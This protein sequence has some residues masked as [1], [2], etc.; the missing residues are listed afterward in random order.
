MAQPSTKIFAEIIPDTKRYEQSVAEATARGVQKGTQRTFDSRGVN[1]LDKGFRGATDSIKGFDRELD[2]ANRRV[3]SFGAAATV[4]YGT[5]RAF[6]E[7]VVAGVAVEKSLAA[8]NSIIK[9]SQR[10]LDTFG[11]SLF[12]VARETG[13]SFRDTAAAALEFSRQ[14]AGAAETAKRTRD[15][16]LLV[17]LT[18]IETTKAVEGLT[19]MMNTFNKTGIDTTQILNKLVAADDA[20]AV[21]AGGLVEAFT[22]VGSVVTDAGASLDQFIGLVTAARQITGRSEAVIG[23]SLKTIFTRIE[24]SDTLDQLEELGIRVRDASGAARNAYSIFTELGTSY[25]SLTREQQKYVAELSAGVFQINQ[26]K[27]LATDLGKANGIAA[28]ATNTA[29]NS[30]NNALIRNAAL[31]KTLATSIQNLKTSATEAA[32]LI[33]SLTLKPTIDFAVGQGN[34]V[35][36]LFA[37]AKASGD[38]KAG[39]DFGAYMG[40]SILKGLGNVLA[41]PGLILAVKAIMGTAIQVGKNAI[42]DV[43]EAGHFLNNSVASGVKR[44]GIGGREAETASLSTVNGLLNQATTAEMK[45]WKAAE[46][47]AQQEAVILSIIER[48]VMALSAVGRASAAPVGLRGGV[49]STPRSAEG[50]IPMAEESA[51]IRAGVGGAPRSARPVYLPGFRR[52]DGMGIV[53]NTS[54]W[55]AP[56]AAGGY[57]AILNREMIG[58]MGLPPGSKPVAAGGYVPNAAKGG[59]PSEWSSA[60]YYKWKPAVPKMPPFGVPPGTPYTQGGGGFGGG[61]SGQGF[62]QYLKPIPSAS[63]PPFGIPPGTPYTQGHGGFGGGASGQGFGQYLDPVANAAAE[64]DATLRRL[65][66]GMAS[67]LLKSASTI[68][69]NAVLAGFGPILQNGPTMPSTLLANQA[70]AGMGGVLPYGPPAPTSRQFDIKHHLFQGGINAYGRK[71][72]FEREIEMLP[73]QPSSSRGGVDENYVMKKRKEQLDRQTKVQAER[74]SFF[75]RSDERQK[76]IAFGRITDRFSRGIGVSPAQQKFFESQLAIEGKQAAARVL[77]PGASEKAIKGFVNDY[78]QT[79]VQHYDRIFNAAIEAK[80]KAPIA[81]RELASA[82][83]AQDRALRLDRTATRVQMGTIGASFGAAF[84]PEGRGGTG[85]GMGYGALSTGLQGSAVGAGLGSL[86]GP[87]GT[88]AG[89]LVGALGGAI[90]GFINKTQKSFEEL[91]GD[92]EESNRRAATQV[93]NASKVFQLDDEEAELRATGGSPRDLAR[94]RRQRTAAIAALTDRETRNLVLNR[95]SNPKAREEALRA[96]GGIASDTMAGGSLFASLATLRGGTMGGALGKQE[97]EI[98]STGL[99]STVAGLSDSQAKALRSLAASNPDLAVATLA[100]MG[101]LSP[102][103]KEDLAPSITSQIATSPMTLTSGLGGLLG[104]GASWLD[105]R[106]KGSVTEV[107]QKTVDDVDLS[108]ARKDQNRTIPSQVTPRYLLKL[109][110]IL[111]RQAAVG[112]ITPEANLRIDEIGQRALLDRPDL[113]GTARIAREGGFAERNIGARA[114]IQR[115]N[116]LLEGRRSLLGVIGDKQN[117]IRDAGITNAV[118][119]AKTLADLKVVGMDKNATPALRQAIEELSIQME[120]LDRTTAEEINITRAQVDIS[121]KAYQDNLTRTGADRDDTAAIGKAMEAFKAAQDRNEDP[122]IIEAA[123]NALSEAVRQQ[124]V[125]ADPSKRPASDIETLRASI[126]TDMAAKR[127]QHAALMG[128]DRKLLLDQSMEAED[129]DLEERILRAQIALKTAARRGDEEGS[130]SQRRI[131]L[132]DLNMETAF[133]DGVMSEEDLRL[134]RLRNRRSEVGSQRFATGQD[135]ESA[136]MAVA[137]E[138]GLQGD[139]M[140]SF[141]GAFGARFEGLKKD[142]KDLSVVGAQVASSLEQNLGNAFGD[143]ITGVQRGKEAFRAFVLGVLGDSARAFASKAVQSLLGLIFSSFTGLS[144]SA[145]AAAIAGGGS[146]LSAAPASFAGKAAGGSIPAMVM[147]G[148]WI[149]GPAEA[150]RIGPA[151]LSALNSGTYQRRAGGGALVTGGSG[152]GDDVKLGLAQGSYVIR[153][154]MVDRYGPATLAGMAAGGMAV[155]V[156]GALAPMDSFAAGGGMGVSIN[157]AISDMATPVPSLLRGYNSGG[158]TASM[159]ATPTSSGGGSGGALSISTSVTINDQRTSSSTSTEGN[160]GM[161]DKRFGVEM[162]RAIDQAVMRKIEEQTRV[163]GMLRIQSLRGNT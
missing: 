29:A 136:S 45:R 117:P 32:G 5:V 151:K 138:R 38:T 157:S 162:A 108:G 154:A 78:V 53:A 18:G 15:A 49:R 6:K 100:K 125:R 95:A 61:A 98:A 141:T 68:N 13:Q 130:I 58:R 72:S 46:G 3:L 99:Q 103:Q 12:N 127:R 67:T 104:L 131:E 113:F 143:F 102:Q 51:A 11:K 21:S 119:E 158:A 81:A 124:L 56:G 129:Q 19:S 155:S 139:A 54:E 24:R 110:N 34:F 33:G 93:E 28:Q 76:G 17:R 148:E 135:I 128:M 132:R 74:A 30:A 79:R 57:P 105:N 36:E 37:N 63:M 159:T 83:A 126:G 43:R 160:A 86:F 20:F 16:M 75:M 122:V 137:Q 60:D 31:N 9:L 27:A 92:I 112:N 109:G 156:N 116:L 90:T 55:I 41:G 80:G 123:A 66:K 14:G 96:A 145:S 70:I 89:T 77:A 25:S 134:S 64:W 152:Y 118:R 39:E 69:A 144:S 111:A 10:D 4:V 35:A 59:L 82:K 121:T 23:N 150:K 163:G 2:R 1:Q 48:Q 140:G 147:K 8:I 85:A 142:L 73:D 115:S 149:Y 71:A 50:Y 40:E 42:L 91:A 26:F 87:I 97:R 22:R 106:R 65:S 7:L 44:L 88:I 52:P 47:V 94:V 114:D 120:A 153:K 133:R 107:L 161:A 146:G 84:L 62:G 101:K